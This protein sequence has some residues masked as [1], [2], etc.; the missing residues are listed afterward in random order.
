MIFLVTGATGCRKKR[1]TKVAHE[2][3]TMAFANEVPWHGLGQRVDTS[4]SVDEMLK[5]AGLD[6]TVSKHQMFC[7]I[8][9]KELKTD[10][11]ALVRDTDSKVLTYSGQ[12]WR[13]V[14][15]K[16]VM[17]FFREWTEAGKVTLETA[18]SLKGGRVVWGLANLKAGYRVTANDWVKG[19][20]LLHAPH[21]VGQAISV[22]VT[23]VRV[24]CANTMAMAIGR[25]SS[26][27]H[28]NHLRDFDVAAARDAVEAAIDL[29]GNREAK[30]KKLL[31]LKISDKDTIRV[32]APHFQPFGDDEEK[33]ET[34]VANPAANLNKRFLQVLDSI[35]SA[36]GAV[37]GTGWGVM[38]GVTH[39]AD[40]V[41]GYKQESRL[42]QAWFGTTGRMKYQVEE[43]LV[44]MA[45]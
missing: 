36:P 20:L 21:E 45:A 31:A 44:K 19:Y 17:E 30:A 29:M 12:D 7:T 42:H 34:M 37:P 8:D 10:R 28:Q 9:G 35:N 16:Q 33:L 22:R 41:A 15:N 18:G 14:Q 39:W 24:V 25:S 23:E 13:P 11:Y 4:I 38:N 3:E 6:W 1:E 26:T 43:D 40:H 27:Y 32:L 2:V 5:A